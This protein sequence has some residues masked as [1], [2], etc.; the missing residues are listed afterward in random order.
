M[1][2]FEMSA[3]YQSYVKF[4]FARCRTIS[5]YNYR[6]MTTKS[7]VPWH[8]TGISRSLKMGDAA[9]RGVWAVS[10]PTDYN[11]KLVSQYIC[12]K[13]QVNVPLKRRLSTMYAKIN[14]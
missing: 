6:N 11:V 8:Y 3:R 5:C 9:D 7:R 14:Q 10:E 1:V 12:L 13:L 4:F 2:L